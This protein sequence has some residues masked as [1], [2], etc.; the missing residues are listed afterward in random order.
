MNSRVPTYYLKNKKSNE[1]YETNFRRTSD[2]RVLTS[3]Y[4]FLHTALWLNLDESPCCCRY[5]KR[6][7]LLPPSVRWAGS[8]DGEVCRG[9]DGVPRRDSTKIHIY[10]IDKIRAVL[11]NVNYWSSSRYRGGRF[12][13]QRFVFLSMVLVTRT[14]ENT[15]CSVR[16]PRQ[17]TCI[18]GER[19]NPNRANQ[20]CPHTRSC[21]LLQ[22]K[23]T[24]RSW[25]EIE[26]AKD[27]LF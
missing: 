22:I 23:S 12:P 11:H 8:A 7:F 6:C 2:G 20:P 24:R 21:Y 27:L 5:C 26:D 9:S 13:I 15:E 18:H 4:I 14:A 16:V 17:A 1:W 19:R 25:R 10:V 3:R